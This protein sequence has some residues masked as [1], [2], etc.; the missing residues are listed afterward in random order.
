MMSAVWLPHIAH[1]AI[2]PAFGLVTHIET[3]IWWNN[4][5][6]C[7]DAPIEGQEQAEKDHVV[8]EEDA[9]SISMRKSWSPNY[10]DIRAVKAQYDAQDAGHKAHTINPLGGEGAC[11]LHGGKMWS[12]W[13]C[14]LWTAK[15]LLRPPE[16]PA[17]EGASR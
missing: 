14:C 8:E 13:S 9:D 3:P 12:S 7:R 15:N 5:W 11:S 16:R 6:I 2:P 1:F 4:T 17:A 10:E